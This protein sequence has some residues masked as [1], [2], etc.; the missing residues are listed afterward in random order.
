MI[1]FDSIIT[2]VSFN[3]E[4]AVSAVVYVYR[5]IFIDA[6]EACFHIFEAEPVLIVFLLVAFTEDLDHDA[7]R[8][9][10]IG[11][12]DMVFLFYRLVVA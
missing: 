4:S 12:R 8:P 7:V 9:V 2:T 1:G 10:M 6:S 3:D 5:A 11:N